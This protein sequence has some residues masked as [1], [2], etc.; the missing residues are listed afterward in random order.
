[1][2]NKKYPFLNFTVDHMTMH[3]V[4]DMYNATY[5]IFRTLFGVSKEDVIYEKRKEWASDQGE[6]S[7]TFAVK[8]GQGIIGDL[9]LQNTIVAL[10]KPSEPKNMPSHSRKLLQEHKAD[11]H[12]QHIALRTSDLLAFHRYALERGVNFITPIMKDQDEDVIQVFSGEWFLPHSNPSGVFFEFTQR[13]PTPELLKKLEEHNRES[14]FRDKTFLGL[15]S[16]K[17]RESQKNEVT[18]FIDHA[19]FLAIQDPVKNKKLWEITEDDVN[20][21]EKIMLEYTKN[22]SLAIKQ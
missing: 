19:L 6:E 13:N 2:S 15:Y 20:K 4:P 10:V 9:S 21:T 12:W 16:E 18:P 11:V 17:E 3:V 22:K 1:M 8:I 5:I 14:W 7:M